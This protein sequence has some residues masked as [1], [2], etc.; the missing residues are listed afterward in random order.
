M[1]S[2]FIKHDEIE[3]KMIIKFLENESSKD[4]FLKKIH[5]FLHCLTKYYPKSR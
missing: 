3:C 2:S 5:K 4:N 1:L